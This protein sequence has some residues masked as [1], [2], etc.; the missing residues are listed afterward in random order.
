MSS[1]R[2]LATVHYGK[3]PDGFRA[4]ESNIPIIGTGGRYGFSTKPLFDGPLV[5][6]ARK[7]TLGNPTFSGG[8]SWVVDTAY[9]VIPY[10][11]VDA[12]WLYYSLSNFNLETLNEATG[13][14]SISRDYLYRVE[15]TTPSLPEQREIARILTTVDNLIEKTEALITKYQAIKQG[16]MYNLF[17]RGVDENGYLRPTYEETPY[18]YKQSV[19]GWIP[20]AWELCR[21]HTCCA[22]KGGFAFRSADFV[23]EG[24]RLVRIGNLF[25]RELDFSRD[26]VFLPHAFIAQY[27]EFVVRAGDI[28][29]SL[30]GTF[31]KQDYGFAVRVPDYTDVCLLNQRVAKFSIT[32]SLLPDFLIRV[33]QSQSYLERLYSL[34]GG[35]KQANLTNQQVLSVLVPVPDVAE[36]CR[37]GETFKSI[38]SRIIREKRV[39]DKVT[40]LKSGLVQDLLTGKV[41][42]MVD[43]PEG[44]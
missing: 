37:I 22:L 29:I 21:L 1:L 16:M 38:D 36:Q 10:E 14:P 31:G 24:V 34:P 7:G 42:V 32:G 6:V 2:E 15:F 12:K 26:P 11:G 28:L 19:L 4:E 40:Y 20:K 44:Q 17:T 30:T 9:A 8:G 25:N 18:L 13:V 35:T 27:P 5:V 39:L 43:E 41:R 3:S 23:N 33:L